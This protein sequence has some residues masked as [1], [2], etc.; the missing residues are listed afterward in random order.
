MELAQLSY[1]LPR[2]T[3][4][5]GR[6]ERQTGGIGSRGPGERKLEVDQRRIR[7]RISDLN[8]EIDALKDHRQVLRKK[9]VES[10]GPGVAAIVGYTNAGKSTLL[11]SLSGG[12]KVYADDKLF[13]T[14]DPTTRRVGLPSGRMILVT[15]TVGFINKLPHD[16]VAAFRATLEE[17]V[18]SNC[19]IHLI[20]ISH[21]DWQAQ[22]DVVNSVLKELGADKV[23]TIYV[24]NKAD[25]LEDRRKR[26]FKR[27]GRILISAKTGHGIPEMLATLDNVFSPKLKPHRF[28]LLYSSNNKIGDIYRLAIINK[29]KYTDK[30]ISFSVESTPEH[31]EIIKSLLAKK[32]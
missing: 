19:I 20:D 11:N 14:L 12:K 7:D 2:I 9:R 18:H 32:A 22:L 10:G 15:D 16:L 29:Q 8:K 31:W 24:Y 23:P 17:I 1:L 5:F 25:L 30:G 28:T 27:E 21:A 13:A 6:F 26:A 3:E 4:R